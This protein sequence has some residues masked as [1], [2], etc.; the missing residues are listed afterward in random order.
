MKCNRNVIFL[1]STPQ[2]L[3]ARASSKRLF[4]T[5]RCDK[6]LHQPPVSTGI[7]VGRWVQHRPGC[8][9]TYQGSFATS[10]ACLDLLFDPRRAIYLLR[11]VDQIWT[12]RSATAPGQRSHRR[13]SCLPVFSDDSQPSGTRFQSWRCKKSLLRCRQLPLRLSLTAPFT[14]MFWLSFCKYRTSCHSGVNRFT[15][16]ILLLARKCH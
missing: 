12:R 5:N 4:G 3:L 14:L 2:P 13:L 16:S 10:P 15:I 11:R 1:S 7:A 8:S 6:V 9:R